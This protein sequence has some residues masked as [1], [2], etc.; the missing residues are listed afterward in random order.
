MMP[1]LIGALL[2]AVAY[3]LA[4]VLQAVATRR[5]P[6]AEGFDPR[7]LVRLAGSLPYLGGLALDAIGFA[8]SV[9]ALRT[10]PLFLVQAAVASSVGV[11]AIAARVWL[12][13]GLGRRE[14]AALWFLGLGL[15]LLAVSA[16]AEQA[17][18]VAV[19][20]QWA[21][22]AGVLPLAGLVAWAGLWRRE[23]AGLGL[24]AGAGLGFVGVGIAA[25]VLTIPQPGWHL[26][27][28]P[29]AWALVGYAA[30]ALY[31]YA[32]ALQR[33]RVTVVAAVT[34]SVETVVPALI[35]LEF[36]GDR[37]RAGFTL[38]ALAGFAATVG[39]ALALAGLADLPATDATDPESARVRP[40]PTD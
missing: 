40:D 10:L 1:G 5:V 12:Q 4:T 20:G 23:R 13:V 22:A 6:T 25:R 17:A 18:A 30:V 7:L 27:A 2:C 3:G 21:L 15:L 29:V 14:V 8:A 32:A 9:L 34:F 36:L 28:S 33:A 11:T 31:C 24:A 26:L 38:V 16:R 35:G 39:G 19:P 37:P